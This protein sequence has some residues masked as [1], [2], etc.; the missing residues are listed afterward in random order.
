MI[1]G[2]NKWFLN[3]K[4]INGRRL[5]EGGIIGSGS[6][7]QYKFGESVFSSKD[8]LETVLRT[9]YKGLLNQDFN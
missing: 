1:Y 3:T 9:E 6:T 2:R 5:A 7:K 8:A 4:S